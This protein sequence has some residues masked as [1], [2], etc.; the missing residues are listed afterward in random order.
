MYRVQLVCDHTQSAEC[1]TKL[2]TEPS[3]TFD[4][5]FQTVVV[6]MQKH[7]KERGW[8][9]DRGTGWRCPA[10]QLARE[11]TSTLQRIRQV[12]APGHT[13]S[14]PEVPSLEDF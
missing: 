2:G 7:A 12:Y 11:S 8:H 14:T 10:C 6:K 13:L 4:R 3:E 1:F 5:H 9:Y